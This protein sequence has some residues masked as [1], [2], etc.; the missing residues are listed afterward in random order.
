M[1]PIFLVLCLG[2]NLLIVG[3]TW[4]DQREAADAVSYIADVTDVIGGRMGPDFDAALSALPETEWK[5]FLIAQT[6]GAEDIFEDF[7]ALSL[8]NGIITFYGVTSKLVDILTQ[9]YARFQAAVDMLA[10]A[11]ASLDM[12]AA[13]LTKN[14]YDLLL[15]TLFRVLTMEGI[16]L[17]VTMALYA[18][19]SEKV[20]RTHLTV[21]SSCTG[22][23]IQISKVLASLL[24]SL[25]GYGLLCLITV[26]AFAALWRLGPIWHE[27]VSTQFYYDF[28]G[29]FITWR[30]FSLAGY[31]ATKLA[32]GA[33]LA[34]VFH[35]LAIA[36][37][38]L[39]E[40]MYRGFIVVLF[41]VAPVALASVV[42]ND[43]YWLFYAAFMWFPFIQWLSG[44][45]WLRDGAINFIVPYQETWTM[46][47][48]LVLGAG[49]VLL[50]LRRFY[51]KDVA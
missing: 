36:A 45:I 50:A 2:L 42:G 35:A 33:A 19:G 9:K 43:G 49:L 23:R 27:S 41:S 44:D 12:A 17:A 3:V 46:A 48:W 14:L 10:E 51:R 5:D 39:T 7:N 30:P 25:G 18:S 37:V 13:G 4:Y 38:L 22:R 20:N 47:L 15:E 28:F 26:G 6:A 34:V 11:G 32:L 1:V 29:P 24:S 8:G 21:Y 31:L 16:L 40:D